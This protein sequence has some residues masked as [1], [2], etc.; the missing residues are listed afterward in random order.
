[1]ASQLPSVVAAACIVFWVITSGAIVLVTEEFRPLGIVVL[2]G[3]ATVSTLVAVCFAARMGRAL[4]TE[5]SQLEAIVTEDTKEAGAG[6]NYAEF[7]RIADRVR[8]RRRGFRDEIELLQRAAFRDGPTGLPNALSLRSALKKALHKCSRTEPAAFFNI[9]LDGL[10]RA[11]DS[12]GVAGSRALL[13]EV[14]ARISMLLATLEA[15]DTQGIKDPFLA[16]L[17]PG[18]FGVLLPRGC[19]RELASKIARDLRL[20]FV[21]PFEI[22]GRSIKADVCG[23]IAMAPDDG[24][25]PETI[26]KN[27]VMAL[28]EVRRSDKQGFQFFTPRLERLAIGRQRFEQELRAAVSEQAFQPVFQPKICFQSGQIVGVEA[29]A[30][31]YRGE[32]RMISPGTFIPLA[33]ELGLVE[34]IG[35][36]IL[37]QSCKAAAEWMRDGYPVAVAVNVAPTQ[38]QQKDFIDQVVD[39]L[40]FAGLPPRFL[41]LEITETMAVSDPQRVID[42]MQPLRAMG[43]KLAIDDFGTGHAN[44]SLLTQ[45]PFDIFKIDRQFVSDLEKDAQSP[46]IV[47]MILAM[48]ETLGL[49]TVAEGVETENQAAFLRRR[50]CTLGQGF[51]FSRGIPDQDLRALMRDWKR[52]DATG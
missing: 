6:S 50:G 31:W 17:G 35:F 2:A 30:R 42:V 18:E 33:E 44:L 1:M 12:L 4:R 45:L 3:L 22:D 43:I 10:A 36:Q 11:S 48:A 28:D 21:Q 8:A 29:L 52:L 47:E 25:L 39:A 32:G 9:R 14:S 40:R 24:D 19:D 41:E 23:G 27:T 49:Q 51:L 7:E 34:E 26:L 38:F 13:A 5:F 37:R 16:A 15:D 46:A 20:L